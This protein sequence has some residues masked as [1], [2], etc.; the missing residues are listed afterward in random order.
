VKFEKLF[1]NGFGALREA[2]LT[3][4]GPGLNIIEGANEAGKTTMLEFVRAL[5]FGFAP[6]A[7]SSDDARRYM[8]SAGGVHGG[9]AIVATSRGDRLRIERIGDKSSSGTPHV[10]MQGDSRA[11]ILEEV[12]R[13]ADRTLY[14]QIFAFSLDELAGFSNSGQSVQDRI[15]A[16]SSGRQGQL[17]LRALE[18]TSS[19][20]GEIYLK[21]GKK[22]PLV[23]AL[24]EFRKLEAQVKELGAQIEN[25]NDAHARFLEHQRNALSQRQEYA[26]LKTRLKSAELHAT[27]WETW[28][29]L[30]A[31]RQELQDLPL[32]MEFEESQFAQMEKLCAALE[33]CDEKLE[34][35]QPRIQRAQKEL[36]ECAVDETILRSVAKIKSLK[37]QLPTYESALRQLPLE[38]QKLNDLQAQIAERVEQLGPQWSVGKIEQFDLSREPRLQIEEFGVALEKHQKLFDEACRAEVTTTRQVAQ[39][40]QSLALLKDEIQKEFPVAPL[41]SPECVRRTEILRAATEVLRKQEEEKVRI[42]YLE[43]DISEKRSLLNEEEQATLPPQNLP[44]WWCAFPLVF[45]VVGGFLLRHQP[46]TVLLMASFFV[47]SA[48]G[49]VWMSRVMAAKEVLR[50]AQAARRSEQQEAQ[51]SALQE[52]IASGEQA[53]QAASAQLQKMGEEFCWDLMSTPGQQR[54][55][56]SLQQERENRIRFENRQREW[57]SRSR[58]GEMLKETLKV[59]SESRA[60]IESTLRDVQE[61]WRVWL[62]E[63]SLTENVTPLQTRELFDSIQKVREQLRVRHQLEEEKVARDKQCRLFGE[64]AEAL[65]TNLGRTIPTP[66]DL[67]LALRVLHE[68]MEQQQKRSIERVNVLKNLQQLQDDSDIQTR[69]RQEVSDQMQQIL[70]NA[71]CA[72]LNEFVRKAEIAAKRAAL[73]EQC[74]AKENILESHSAPGAARLQLED[75][76]KNLD[77]QQV[78]GSLEAM[79]AL[80]AEAEEELSQTERAQGE[81]N[82]RIQQL[83]QSEGQLTALLRQLEIQKTTIADL[84]E[85][86][87]VQRVMNVVLDCARARF[88]RER[89]PAV[90]KR[91]GALMQGVSAGRYR[92]VLA[93]GGLNTLELD[94]GEE[95]RKPL[96]HWSRGTK[97]QVYLALRLAFIEDYC[98]RENT[99][100]LPVVMDDVL[101]HADGYQ[102][103]AAAS[104]MIAEFAEKHQVLYFTCRPL[105]AELL[106]K[107]SPTAKHFRLEQGAFLA[108]G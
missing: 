96:S 2:E 30:A 5:F 41:S 17:L 36:E 19:R 50:T 43:R 102:R 67:P 71:E 31:L 34:A 6:R 22:Q 65:W 37:E 69:K 83:E 76:L 74:K 53:T 75:E 58:D 105:D 107:A 89:Q 86:W 62:Q 103:L 77:A 100:A 101:V 8:P 47:A 90:I 42:Q 106:G 60:S 18:R 23:I 52:Q 78:R 88:E 95:R 3:D 51:L 4:I 70:A 59:Q 28:V 61:R 20:A 72:D 1:V 11:M 12:L 49:V 29:Q 16:A 80:C 35:L 48:V 45:A 33:Q 81:W 9:W 91:A 46:L 66:H 92:A 21:Q 108:A 93:T 25:Y 39:S 94:E 56:D 104:A 73:Q 97:E 99:V 27:V 63:R 26:R 57:E 55:A 14:E 44:L 85:Q 68:E 10:Q 87:A 64:A 32:Q 79:Q 24:A 15:Y 40:E 82:N 84:T 54:A 7:K 98:S 13:G 38:Q